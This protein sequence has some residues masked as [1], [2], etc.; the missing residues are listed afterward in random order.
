MDALKMEGV[1]LTYQTPQRETE[2]L[3]NVNFTVKKGEFIAIVGPSGCGKTTILS[4]IAG[5]IRPNS[6]KVY[7]N[8]NEI[9]SVSEK[10]GYMLQKD[11]LFD[12]RTVKQNITLGLEIKKLN[13]AE[14]LDYATSLLEKYGL[15]EF[16]HHYPYQLSG[17]M[18]QRVALIRT[19]AFKPE[20][21]LL[22]EP[23]S[24]LDFQT[25]LAVC[26][27][28]YKIIKNENKTTILVTHDISEAVSLADKIIVLTKRP[29]TVKNVYEIKIDKPTPFLKREDPNFSKWFNTIWKEVV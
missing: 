24:A 16:I 11:Q 9:N 13:L 14:N 3:K 28:V 15:L 8:G 2:A 22:D 7:I 26:D 19:L 12:W 18:R 23:F 10:I 20:V 4:L 27:D 21:L 17:G 6:G 29:A 25:R 1:G 5:L